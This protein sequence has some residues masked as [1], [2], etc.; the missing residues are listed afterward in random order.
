[1][2]IRRRLT[3]GAG[4]REAWPE[5][6]PPSIHDEG[7]TQYVIYARAS[8]RRRYEQ[9]LSYQIE[10]IE[11]FIAER[12]GQAIA[13]FREVGQAEDENL[14]ERLNAINLAIDEQAIL[15]VRWIDRFSR[16]SDFVRRWLNMN[17]RLQTVS[18]PDASNEQLRTLAF[19]ALERQVESEERLGEGR[20]RARQRN[21]RMGDDGTGAEARRRRARRR[22][23]R[24][25]IVVRQLQRSGF[26]TLSA[27]AD[28]LNN[29][30]VRT[31]SGRGRWTHTQVDR[32]R[33]TLRL[34]DDQRD[35]DLGPIRFPYGVWERVLP[36]IFETEEQAL[37]W[38]ANQ[39]ARIW[40]G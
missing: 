29:I 10:D 30:G 5:Q 8:T 3:R 18:H 23:T 27:V 17:L 2:A 28:E 40:G 19:A 11:D 6:F 13:T 37:A 14:P 22:A 1:M 39:E 38:I 31:P 24:V 12:E 7:P 32:E 36:Q 25:M 4:V 20:Y 15:I 33:R 21:Q 35:S 34:L 16:D 26:D 9:R